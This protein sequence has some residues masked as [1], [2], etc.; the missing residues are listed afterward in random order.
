MDGKG[1]RPKSCGEN[2][3]IGSDPKVVERI[4]KSDFCF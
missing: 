4:K 1:I 3:K 2:K